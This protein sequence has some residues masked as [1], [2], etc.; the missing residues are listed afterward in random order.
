MMFNVAMYE[1][2]YDEDAFSETHSEDSANESSV[3]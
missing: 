1:A 3:N 2:D